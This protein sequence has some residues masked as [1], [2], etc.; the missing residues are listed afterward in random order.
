M[1][2]QLARRSVLASLVA[3]VG[4]CVGGPDA[5]G[6]GTA[7]A[8]ATAGSGG[9]GSGTAAAA[10]PFDDAVVSAT[11]AVLSAA[12]VRGGGARQAVVIDPL[13]DGVTGDQSAATQ[14]IGTRIVQV[15]QERYPQFD[16]QPFSSAA[17]ARGPYALMGTFTPV[18]ARGQT[19]GARDS[20]RFCLIMADLQ[21]NR[22]VAKRVTRA[23]PGG[24]D[25]T[26]TT[27]FRDSPAW[28]DDASIRSYVESCQATRVGDPV[29]PTYLT[30][31][32]AAAIVAQAI[33]AYAAGRY[34]EAIG[35]YQD[36]QRTNAGDQL[37]V[38][39]GLYLTN[40]KLGRRQEAE[41]AFGQLV[42]YSLRN[43]RLAVKL[44]FRP[45]STGLVSQ[46]GSTGPYD[47]WL[48]QIAAGAAQRNTCLQVTG[49]T[50][51]SGA[52]ALNERLSLLRAEF[53]KSRLETDAPQLRGK[54]IAAGA[55]TKENMVGTGADDATDALDRRVEFTVLNSCT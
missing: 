43:R 39:N 53:V 19:T 35:L 9:E 10:L 12:P 46:D 47:M 21:S 48:R 28:T 25:T 24:V 11:N 27:F 50:S 49:H 44:L 37:R 13:V 34:A 3:A 36:A 7:T 6:P 2:T 1:E 18:N 42:D 41:A 40:W 17:V 4:G 52:A 54:L 5:A 15:A 32:L 20:L 33:D 31:I 55:G 30:G 29:S 45:G 14:R 51:R 8:A 22:V 26:P 23:L 38:H 16:I